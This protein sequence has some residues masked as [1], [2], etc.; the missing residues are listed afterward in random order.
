VGLLEGKVAFITGG[1]R[2][3][4]RAHAVTCAREG[5]DVILFDAPAQLSAVPYAMGTADD[6][7]ETARLVGKEGRRAVVAEGDVRSQADLDDAVTRAIDTFGKI[8]ILIANA[9]VWYAG[10]FWEFS[11][12]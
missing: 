12:N 9:G 7:E 2:G 4:G 1:A 10:H 11:E 8:D 5:A 3:Q 6:L